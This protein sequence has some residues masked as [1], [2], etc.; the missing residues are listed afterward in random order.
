MALNLRDDPTEDDEEE[1]IIHDDELSNSHSL[2]ASV[3]EH[4]SRPGTPVVEAEADEEPFAELLLCCECGKLRHFPGHE[5]AIEMGKEHLQTDELPEEALRVLEM[6]DRAAQAAESETTEKF[7][8]V[9]L[10]DGRGDA[11]DESLASSVRSG[12]RVA[13]FNCAACFW[14]PWLAACDEEEEPWMQV[15]PG[16]Q[17]CLRSPTASS[18]VSV[19]L[20]LAPP[21]CHHRNVRVLLHTLQSLTLHPARSV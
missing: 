12:H 1:E 3:R 19:L 4:S 2:L 13:G 5:L 6:L 8:P 20:S 9:V 16:K 17:T 21:H 7:V 18:F 14:T 11:D 15:G 10:A